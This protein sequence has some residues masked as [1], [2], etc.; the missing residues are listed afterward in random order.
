MERIIQLR[1][2]LQCSLKGLNTGVLKWMNHAKETIKL[3]SMKHFA[4]KLITHRQIS[5]RNPECY[6]QMTSVR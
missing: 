1:V 2:Q 5:P 4:S 3:S 6:R